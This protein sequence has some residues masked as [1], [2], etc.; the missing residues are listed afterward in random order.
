LANGNLYGTL[1]ATSAVF[2]VNAIT[3][4]DTLVSKLDGQEPFS[5]VIRDLAGNLYGTTS[6]GGTLNRGTIFKIA[7]S[8]K[9]SVLHNFGR[10]AKTPFGGLTIDANG[11]LYGTTTYGGT[12]HNGIVFE[13]SRKGAYTVL[14]NFKGGTDGSFPDHEN[15]IIDKAGN[16]YGTTVQGGSS[17]VGTVFKLNIKTRTET[18]LYSFIDFGVDGANP[19]AGLIRD[20]N[21]NLFGTASQGGS[22]G[23]GVVFKVDKTGKETVLYTFQGV[24]DGTSPQGGLIRDAMGNLYGTTIY[25]GVYGYGT[26]F[27]LDTNGV[28]TVLHSFNGHDGEAPTSSLVEDATGNLYGTTVSGGSAGYGV[29]FKIT[30]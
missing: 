5:G 4:A 25:G 6:L 8:G 7:G 21:G 24:P 28:E 13:L 3:G 10:G 20:A 12:F 23:D 15:L 11:N 26:A 9:E 17:G 22:S 14:Y 1:L 27:K 30:P 16:L 2:T 29:V 18:L 19:S